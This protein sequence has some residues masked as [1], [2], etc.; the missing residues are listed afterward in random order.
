MSHLN[1]LNHLK[2][3]H[4]TIEKWGESAQFDQT[5]EECAELI[6]ALHHY[7]RKKVDEQVLADEIA[8]VALMLGQLSSM[9]G[10]DLVEDAIGRKLTKLQA[11][12]DDPDGR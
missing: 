4:A 5:V 9:I 11:L 1:L 7:K 6:A 10:F 8:D 2:T 3:Y 12:L